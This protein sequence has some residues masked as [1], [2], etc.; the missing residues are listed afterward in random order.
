[1]EMFKLWYI[2]C[3]I[4]VLAVI[5]NDTAHQRPATRFY[6]SLALPVVLICCGMIVNSSKAT[7]ADDSAVDDIVILCR[8]FQYWNSQLFDRD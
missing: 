7:A 8:V 4:A 3:F 5:N 1:M 2:F 6:C